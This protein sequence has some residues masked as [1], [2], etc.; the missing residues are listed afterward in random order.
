MKIGNPPMFAF[1]VNLIDHDH[2]PPD[3][4]T[5]MEKRNSE[6]DILLCQLG[7]KK[8]PVPPAPDPSQS[9]N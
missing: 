1:A 5:E 2:V 3:D 6:M 8:V 7:Y 9:C 4:P